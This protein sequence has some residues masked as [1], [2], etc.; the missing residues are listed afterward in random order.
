L[1]E[2]NNRRRNIRGSAK[3][4]IAT[5]F[6]EKQRNLAIPAS[7]AVINNKDSKQ[8][9][10]PVKAGPF[11]I[12]KAKV[13]KEKHLSKLVKKTFKAEKVSKRD[14]SFDLDKFSKTKLENGLKSSKFDKLKTEKF[15]ALKANIDKEHRSKFP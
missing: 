4:E 1:A 11:K 2:G 15:K 7:D 6:D 10:S 9:T 5:L 3:E 14:K 12:K 8:K 13:E